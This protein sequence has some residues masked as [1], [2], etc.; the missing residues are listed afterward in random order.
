MAQP[1]PQQQPSPLRSPTA[2][3]MPLPPIPAPQVPL[4]QPVHQQIP[5]MQPQHM[6]QLH[7]QQHL[8]Q[9]QQPQ[10]PQQIRLNPQQ[11]QHQQH[12]QQQIALH[13]HLANLFSSQGQALQGGPL[14]QPQH[15]GQAPSA[16][17]TAQRPPQQL[18][19]PNPYQPYPA[20]LPPPAQAYSVTSRPPQAPTGQPPVAAQYPYPPQYYGYPPQ[21]MSAQMNSQGLPQQPY[22]PH[23]LPQMMQG[24]YPQ[25]FPPQPGQ[26]PYL[27]QPGMPQLPPPKPT[28]SGRRGRNTLAGRGAALAGAVGPQGG[29]LAAP[30]PTR[31]R[32]AASKPRATAKKP[33]GS[34]SAGAHPIVHSANASL[35]PADPSDP[36]AT[37]T[38][39]AEGDQEQ[40]FPDAEL[41]LPPSEDESDPDEFQAQD[42]PSEDE[43]SDAYEEGIGG[44]GGGSRSRRRRA[45]GGPSST[46]KRPAPG[47]PTSSSRRRAPVAVRKPTVA[48]GRVAV[49]RPGFSDGD[50]AMNPRADGPAKAPDEAAK[51][52]VKLSEGNSPYGR[53]CGLVADAVR[54]VEAEGDG[55][56]AHGQGSQ[57]NGEEEGVHGL[58]SYREMEEALSRLRVENGPRVGGRNRPRL[59]PYSLDPAADMRRQAA[60][61]AKAARLAAGVSVRSGGPGGRRAPSEMPGLDALPD[62]YSLWMLK[63]PLGPRGEGRRGTTGSGAEH[64]DEDGPGSGKKGRGKTKSGDAG[65]TGSDAGAEDT[66]S[67]AGSP[68]PGGAVVPATVRAGAAAPPVPHQPGQQFRSD[69]FLYGHPSGRRFR[70]AGEFAIHVMWLYLS[71]LER[72]RHETAVRNRLSLPPDA[73]ISPE[74]AWRPDHS[75]CACVCCVPWVA[76]T[77]RERGGGE[78]LGRARA[79][80]LT[81]RGRGFPRGVRVDQVVGVAIPGVE[82]RSKAKKTAVIKGRGVYENKDV[83]E[84]DEKSKA[85]RQRR[86]KVMRHLGLVAPSDDF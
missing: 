2:A 66:S 35:G 36:D 41:D 70:S 74:D 76:E 54:G 85:N 81:G 69:V 28:S 19:Y 61:A 40:S 15:S 5:P 17:P 23:L 80:A 22:P 72:Q 59:D 50:E 42:A 82:A 55:D 86:L 26:M 43:D 63:K 37:G 79:P 14:Q 48:G 58:K 38:F 83:G 49:A 51:W 78:S 25:P 57:G 56:G 24:G 9:Q 73:P 68:A 8:Q 75:K 45:P 71:T 31:K 53:W 13:Q 77:E 32:P 3:S 65:A 11:Q 52:F 44:A 30:A 62:G 20:S 33:R 29:F 6:Q 46:R 4:P 60:L 34:A 7:Q 10:Q 16:S 39:A 21:A 1:S 18:P 27:P 84:E 12:Q 67:P 47:G 64:G